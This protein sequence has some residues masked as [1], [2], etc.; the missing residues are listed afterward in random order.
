[1]IYSR[2]WSVWYSEL[3]S[4]AGRLLTG[5]PSSPVR[6]RWAAWLIAAYIS[7]RYCMLAR[8]HAFFYA[9]YLSTP[10]PYHMVLSREFSH[11]ECFCAVTTDVPSC[12]TI[13]TTDQFMLDCSYLPPSVVVPSST[14][15]NIAGV[16]V[17]LVG[18]LRAC[19]NQFR[20]LESHRVHVRT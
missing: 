9:A 15:S 14:N 1:M 17:G 13:Y 10:R 11:L 5:G 7:T 19:Q 6:R 2:S 8:P 16:P 18:G 12:T 3:S 20:G 4:F